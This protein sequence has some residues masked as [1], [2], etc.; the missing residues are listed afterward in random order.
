MSSRAHRL[1]SAGPLALP[2]DNLSSLHNSGR[3]PESTI[4]S[5]YSSH[6]CNASGAPGAPRGR[7]REGSISAHAIKMHSKHDK[8]QHSASRKKNPV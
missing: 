3:V 8:P 7:G 1:A 4:H 6:K 2:A 5:L